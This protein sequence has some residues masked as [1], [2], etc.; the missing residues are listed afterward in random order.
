MAFVISQR[1]VKCGAFESTCHNKAIVEEDKQIDIDYLTCVQ[2]GA[3]IS[4]CKFNA[5]TKA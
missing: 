1:C 3:C 2:C 4:N 5:I